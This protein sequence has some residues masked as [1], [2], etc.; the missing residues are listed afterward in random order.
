VADTN[1]ASTTIRVRATASVTAN[2]DELNLCTLTVISAHGGEFPGTVTTN[3]GTALS[4][5]LTNSPVSSGT[6]Q[7]VCTGVSVAGNAFAQSGPTNV[8]LTLTNSATVTWQWSTNYWFA[9]ES[10]T[11]GSVSGSTNGW[12]ASGSTVSLAAAGDSGY[13]F[14]DWAGDV[15]AGQ[16][17]D[18]PLVLLMDAPRSALAQF[19][20]IILSEALNSPN[21]AWTTGGSAFWRGQGATSH[22]GVCAAQSGVAGDRQTSW[23]RTSANGTG[24]L[25]F[26]WK[27]SSEA[28][29]DF[30][31]F[32]VDGATW[33]EISGSAEWQ[34]IT[35]RIEGA[36]AHT[37]DW[38]YTKDKDTSEGL[39]A[40][41][42][43][44]VAWVPD[45]Q[46][47]T[48]G[49]PYSWLDL[50][51]VVVNGDYESADLADTDGDGLFAWQEYVAGTLPTNALSVFRSELLQANGQIGLRWTPDLTGAVPARVYSVYG[52][53]NLLDG[54]KATSAT[55]LS[56]GTVVPAQTLAP[57]RYFKV[58]VD[59]QP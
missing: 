28:D 50:Y 25:S 49:T 57:N 14:A 38:S 12:Y 34:Q 56:A 11:N 7:Y 54:F 2:F 39:D 47:T 46:A 27:V 53:S 36:G 37:L 8:L 16:A 41:W 55:N 24:S 13:R 43:D 40:G 23:L 1:A 31:K 10:G 32:K 19:A 51:G 29:Y 33:R 3:W 44:Q 35:L 18:N 52:A 58:G 20:V 42:V 59:L 22:D 4:L 15:P 45:V 30:L 6:T 5:W 26:W 48:Q 21:L 9:R 17:H